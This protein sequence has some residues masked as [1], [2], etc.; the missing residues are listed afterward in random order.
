MNNQCAAVIL[1]LV[2]IVVVWGDILIHNSKV[3]RVAGKGS[4]GSKYSKR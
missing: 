2:A 4:A 3:V 1:V